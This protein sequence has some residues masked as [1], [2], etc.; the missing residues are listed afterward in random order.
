[1]VILIDLNGPNAHVLRKEVSEYIDD[2]WETM[3]PMFGVTRRGNEDTRKLEVKRGFL[4]QYVVRQSVGLEGIEDEGN[5]DFSSDLTTPN[6]IR[7][8]VKTEG[9]SFDFQKEY[10]GSGGVMRQAKHNF[11]PRQLYDPNLAGTD[12]F[13]VVRMRTGDTF[14]GSG[15]SR[16]KRWKM[17]VCGWVSKKRVINEGVLIPRGGITEQ[18][19]SFF[20]YRSHN[21]E[22]YQNAL[23]PVES[24][25]D[26]FRGLARSD[27]TRDEALDPD[28][29]MQ[30]TIAD[31][32]RIISNLLAR[33]VIDREQFD[34]INRAI[35]LG[36]AHVPPVLHS[37]H[38]VRFV[39]HMVR[40]GL[41][42]RDALQKLDG[43]GITETRPEALDELKR[44]FQ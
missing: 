3:K 25:T 31:A 8:D 10:A 4:A 20:A 13:L 15:S 40:R 16:E 36:G 42:S 2:N 12:A 32:Q 30:C 5:A 35:G 39:R 41:L 28:T 21:V 11:H 27:V 1:M 44:F 37:N 18:G 17:W 24:L 6:G 14:P 19:G 23:N 34:S 33:G 9:A 26:W 22:F 43:V 38:T 7:I 29:T